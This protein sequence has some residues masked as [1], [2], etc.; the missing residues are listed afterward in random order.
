MPGRKYIIYFNGE[1]TMKNLL[2]L[3]ILIQF[4]LIPKFI[5]SSE[6]E[7]VEDIEKRYQIK[8]PDASNQICNQI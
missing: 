1:G 3:L 5:Y 4:I 2:C 7:K 8:N 6:V